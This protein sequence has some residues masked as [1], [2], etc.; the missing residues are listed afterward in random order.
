[1]SADI[2][3]GAPVTTLQKVGISL[4]IKSQPNSVVKLFI[5]TNLPATRCRVVEQRGCVGVL[6]ILPGDGHWENPLIGWASSYAQFPE[7]NVRVIVRVRGGKCLREWEK[8]E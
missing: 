5:N 4:F 7:R 8:K 1:M 3:S 2:I 6:T